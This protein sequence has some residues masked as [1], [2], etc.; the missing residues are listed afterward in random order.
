M[1]TE[2]LTLSPR[3]KLPSKKQTKPDIDW[4]C[5]SKQ[6]TYLRKNIKLSILL[7]RASALCS[8]PPSILRRRTAMDRSQKTEIVNMCM[9]YKDDLVLVQDKLDENYKGLC[10]PGGHVELTESLTDAVIRE[11]FEE[12]GLTIESPLLCGTKDWVNDDG[13]RYLALFYK[14]DKFSGEIKSSEEGDILWM[15]LDDLLSMGD[16][17]SLDMKDMIKIFLNDNL[18]EFFYYKENKKWKYELK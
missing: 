9:V 7:A 16:R 10:F 1:L 18:S 12:T 5:Y 13:S 6:I 14:T 4:S 17:L 3:F 8:L 2:K 11:V 15:R